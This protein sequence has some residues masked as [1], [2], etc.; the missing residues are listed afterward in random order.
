MN[1]VNIL[2]VISIFL[3]IFEKQRVACWTVGA[4]ME[5]RC[6]AP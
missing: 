2:E 4:C 1:I 5:E 3:P 6:M